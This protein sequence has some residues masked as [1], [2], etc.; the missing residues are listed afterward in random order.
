MRLHVS[1]TRTGA[2]VVAAAALTACSTDHEPTL[3]RNDLVTYA[4]SD[5]VPLAPVRGADITAWVHAVDG[6]GLGEWDSDGGPRPLEYVRA[7]N[8]PIEDSRIDADRRWWSLE[9]TVP[10]EAGEYTATIRALTDADGGVLVLY[11][12]AHYDLYAADLPNAETSLAWE[13][14]GALLQTCA[15]A[16]GGAAISGEALRTWTAEQMATAQQAYDLDERHN[17]FSVHDALEGDGGVTAWFD[18]DEHYSTVSISVDPRA[19]EIS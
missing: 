1:L 14:I 19:Q 4:A 8:E 2:A 11:C 10:H 13:D 3:H 17:R 15:G 6:L 16:S 7:V 12:E 18:S 5:P 9:E